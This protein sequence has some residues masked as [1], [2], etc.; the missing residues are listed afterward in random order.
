MHD[1]GK[2]SI[3]ESVIDKA[4]KLQ[5]MIDGIELVKERAQIKEIMRLLFKKRN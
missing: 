2:I 3:P 4:T 5:F 1:I